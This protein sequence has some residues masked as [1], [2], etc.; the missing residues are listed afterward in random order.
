[1][2]RGWKNNGVMS[3]NADNKIVYKWE[4]NSKKMV[5]SVKMIN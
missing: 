4:N 3:I 5:M 1:M 2:N